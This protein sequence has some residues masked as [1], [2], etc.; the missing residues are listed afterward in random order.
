MRTVRN[1]RA[2]AA[3]ALA[4]VVAAGCDSVLGNEQTLGRFEWV[5]L[6][7]PAAETSQFSK[8]GRDVVLLGTVNTT[9]SC[10]ELQPNYSESGSTATLRVRAVR[11]NRP[12]CA[13]GATTYQYEGFLRDVDDMATLRII[14]DVEGETPREY[15][16]DLTVTA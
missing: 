6:P 8:F 2:F 4:C 14:H 11:T 1:W 10:Y 12:S 7:S 9:A 5:E 3:A 16:H 13:E 15:I